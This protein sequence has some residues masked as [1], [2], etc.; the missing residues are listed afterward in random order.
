MSEKN[1]DQ[2][3]LRQTRK[4]LNLQIDA[5]DDST[6]SALSHIR[7][8]AIAQLDSHSTK[9]KFRQGWYPILAATATASVIIS[10]AITIN[11][12]ATTDRLPTLEDMPLITATDD[13]M[14]YQDLE[15]YQWLDAEKVN[16]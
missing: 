8:R 4:T 5:I 6:R 10:I 1:Q 12:S 15:F 7:R 13:I 14:F 3:F 16:G 9:S 11:M 2:E